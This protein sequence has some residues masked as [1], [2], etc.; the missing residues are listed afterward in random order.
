MIPAIAF[1]DLNHALRR[2]VVGI[3]SSIDMK[4]RRIK[5]RTRWVQGEHL[6][7][8]CSHRGIHVRGIRGMDGIQGSAQRIVIELIGRATSPKSSFHGYSAKQ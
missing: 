8:L 1:G 5:M 4:T 2:R 6:T 3:I 7:P